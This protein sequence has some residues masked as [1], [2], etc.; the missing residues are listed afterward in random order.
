MYLFR[1][2]LGRSL[3]LTRQMGAE[4]PPHLVG[5]PSL[6]VSPL[7]IPT[8]FANSIENVKIASLIPA[9]LPE[10]IVRPHLSWLQRAKQPSMSFWPGFP[11]QQHVARRRQTSAIRQVLRAHKTRHGSISSE[12]PQLRDGASPAAS[13]SWRFLATTEAQDSNSA[14]SPSQPRSD[15][16]CR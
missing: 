1:W 11:M 12:F 3:L 6:P 16:S 2:N 9:V 10:P 14:W 13:V 15:S 7:A 4:L 8:T 5:S